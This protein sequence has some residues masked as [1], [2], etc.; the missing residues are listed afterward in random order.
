MTYMGSSELM[1]S[2]ARQQV[3]PEK[4]EDWTHGYAYKNFSFINKN[5][6]TVEING[7]QPIFL[8]IEQGFESNGGNPI[9]SFVIV[10]SGIEYQW[11]GRY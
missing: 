4:P 7:G 10:E 5:A 1:L 6:C 9:T 11:I 8:D 2:Q 3:I